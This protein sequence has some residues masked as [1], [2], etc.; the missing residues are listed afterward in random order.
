MTHFHLR[1]AQE[2]TWQSTTSEG[3]TFYCLAPRWKCEFGF[4]IP[5]LT[6]MS[7]NFGHFG[8]WDNKINWWKRWACKW[9]KHG[10]KKRVEMRNIGTHWLPASLKAKFQCKNWAQLKRGD[11]L[12]SPDRNYQLP[13]SGHKKLF[14]KRNKSSRR[15]TLAPLR[16]AFHDTNSKN[17][18]KKGLFRAKII[19][20]SIYLR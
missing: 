5:R 14:V 11:S 4:R 15:V 7:Q 3:V 13:R 10:K 16:C 1:S 18:T 19:G 12:L 20:Y 2:D 17:K 6:Q 8:L 9:V